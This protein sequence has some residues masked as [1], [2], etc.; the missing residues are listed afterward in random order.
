[1]NDFTAV[2]E[3]ASTPEIRY[4]SESQTAIVTPKVKLMARYGAGETFTI[5]SVAFG[6]V[7]ESIANMEQG[8]IVLAI[9]QL[10][11]LSIDRG[12]Y[13]EYV[14]SFKISE[15]VA[16]MPMLIAFNK[17]G[18]A[19][20]VGG[21][22][23]SKYFGSGKNN[24]KFSIAVRR[25]AKES[26]W[27]AIE[28]W[29]E[30]AKVCDQYVAKGSK[31]GASGHLKIETWTDKNTGQARSKPVIVADRVSLL[32]K[33]GDGSTDQKS[34]QSTAQPAAVK[35]S[36]PPPRS[37]GPSTGKPKAVKSD[38]DDIPF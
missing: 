6:K 20:N 16:E 33:G 18:I 26:D 7:A 27:F 19:G 17:V 21:D 13:K 25:T 36:N 1:M 32:G 31:L 24:A 8:P 5:E 28:C 30:T 14:A 34:Y 12:N 2:I 37:S 11:I 15:V 3:F 29:S 4:T 22:V 9:G 38:F 23:D 10:N 35:S